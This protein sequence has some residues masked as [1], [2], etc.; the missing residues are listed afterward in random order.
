MITI[1]AQLSLVSIGIILWCRQ[2]LDFKTK[3][4][5]F[6][7][8]LPPH[9]ADEYNFKCY[10]D[11]CLIMDLV[12][13]NKTRLSEFRFALNVF[14]AAHILNSNMSN[15]VG[16]KTI[17]IRTMKEYIHWNLRDSQKIEKVKKFIS[18]VNDLS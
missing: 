2:S 13:E 4:I 7:E 17:F 11:L 9:P 12:I 5:E 8:Y 18:E 16:D 6:L 3:G 15:N 1:L 10:N 14:D